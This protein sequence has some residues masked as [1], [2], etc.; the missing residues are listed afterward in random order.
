MTDFKILV[1]GNDK[2]SG[3]ARVNLLRRSTI[4]FHLLHNTCTNNSFVLYELPKIFFFEERESK[5]MLE[6]QF[7]FLILQC[8]K[9]KQQK[10]LQSFAYLYRFEAKCLKSVDQ[11]IS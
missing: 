4:K 6:V 10:K 2:M 9:K 7:R 11:I 5:Q 8:C 1:N 3:N